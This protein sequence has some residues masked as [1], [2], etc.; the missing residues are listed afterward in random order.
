M[1]WGLVVV[2]Y[3]QKG[4]GIMATSRK[5]TSKTVTKKDLAEAV[6]PVKAE[7]VEEAATTLKPEKIREKAVKK[8]I[9]AKADEDSSTNV[10][11]CIEALRNAVNAQLA[12][13]A[14]K[15]S[16]E[17]AKYLNLQS[18][19]QL[20]EAELKQ[21]YD[22]DSEAT[23]L[24]ALIEAQRIKEE[25]FK[26][27]EAKWKADFAEEKAEAE[28][29]LEAKTEDA[30]KLQERKKE[31]YEYNWKRE[32]ERKRT[33]L[34]D[35]LTALRRNIAS[36][37]QTFDDESA[38][39]S[40]ELDLREKEI[41]QKEELL[42]TLQQEAEEFPET[43]QK[44]VDKACKSLEARLKAEFAMKDQLM[45]KGF[46]GDKNVY[47]AKIA[48]MKEIV[49][50]QAKQLVELAQRQEKAYNQVQDIATKAVANCGK[51]IF[52]QT[53]EPQHAKLT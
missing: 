27:E 11:Q 32:C 51:T 29:E 40:A 36:E 1:H 22:I 46:E 35:E 12:D 49:D 38:R 34:E 50:S 33:E 20:K 2:R 10:M 39:R 41:S 5:T 6:E 47:E 44:E 18:A 13:L 45:Q 42:A 16:A 21:I 17:T 25:E 26:Q 52:A 28:A 30:R 4:S 9:L 19:I 43:L 24:L 23:S 37:R 31:E 8:E 7:L 53:Q 15:L 3:Q 48:S 14:A